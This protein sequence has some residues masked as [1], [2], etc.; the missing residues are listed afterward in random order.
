[1]HSILASWGRSNWAK[2]VIFENEKPKKKQIQALE[3]GV[4]RPNTENFT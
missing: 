3:D 4:L 1:M 2:G